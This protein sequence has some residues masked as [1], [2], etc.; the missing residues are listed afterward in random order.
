MRRSPFCAAEHEAY[1][2]R[3]TAWAAAQDAAYEQN[4]ENIDAAALAALARLASAS[5]GPGGTKV[6][7]DV[8]DFLDDL[9]A[10]APDCG[11][12]TFRVVV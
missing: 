10:K 12:Q 4:S 6:N 7:A 8:G 11:H 1:P 3:I 5:R 9:D 2:A